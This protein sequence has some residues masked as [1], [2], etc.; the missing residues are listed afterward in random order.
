MEGRVI[1]KLISIQKRRPPCDGRR[2]FAGR[3]CMNWRRTNNSL[4]ERRGASAGWCSSPT[5]LLIRPPAARIEVFRSVPWSFSHPP[6]P[7]GASLPQFIAPP[8]PHL[9]TKE[10]PASV[11]FQ[12]AIVVIETF[13]CCRQRIVFIIRQDS[14]RPDAFRQQPVSHIDGLAEIHDAIVIAA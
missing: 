5:I 9:P 12:L 8:E 6:H 13:Q 11:S 1:S 4:L 2:F 7:G 3:R 14:L 10:S